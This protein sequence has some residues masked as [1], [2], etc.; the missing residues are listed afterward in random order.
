MVDGRINLLGIA[1]RF[2]PVEGS[3]LWGAGMGFQLAGTGRALSGS[4]ALF[5]EI[6]VCGGVETC[7][8]ADQ[9]EG[10]FHYTKEA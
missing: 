8:D 7:A 4:G 6:A 10:L 2:G 1:A 5:D 9:D 3:G